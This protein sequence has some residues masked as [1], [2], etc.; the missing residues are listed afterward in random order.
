MTDASDE[1]RR[2]VV[3]PGPGGVQV[4]CDDIAP[5]VQTDTATISGR[6]ADR[7][8]RDSD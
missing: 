5:S 7:G 3:G 6:L 8:P 2:V 1:L 4:I